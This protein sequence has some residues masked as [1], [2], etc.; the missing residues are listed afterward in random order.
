MSGGRAQ[1][2]IA[3][4]PSILVDEEIRKV[5]VS[6]HTRLPSM[7]EVHIR[8]ELELLA[9]GL[10][11]TDLP[12]LL[13][14]AIVSI[15]AVPVDPSPLPIG[16]PK[17]LITG[18][19]TSFEVVFDAD[20]RATLIL[21]GYDKSHRLHRGRKTAT[22]LMMNDAAIVAQVASSCGLLP[23]I[24]AGNMSP[25]P[26]II[27]NDLTDWD[28]LQLR[29]SLCGAQV[30]VD[31]LGGLHFSGMDLPISPL[32]GPILKWGEALKSFQ[33]RI[34]VA[35]QSLAAAV[36][37]MNVGLP[38]VGAGVG[39][40]TVPGMS[41]RLTADLVMARTVTGVFPIT[42]TSTNVGTGGDASTLGKA[43]VTESLMNFVRAEGVAMGD[44]G[45]MAGSKVMI[46][47]VG[48]RF[49]G[50]Y[51]VSQATHII[52][53]EKRYETHFTVGGSESNTL[54]SLIKGD[55]RREIG[56]MPGVVVGIVTNIAGVTDTEGGD[57]GRV[58]VKFAWM[59]PMADSNWA[60]IASPMAGLSNGFMFMPEVGDEVLVAFEHG[61]V[62][63]PYVVGGLWN[64]THKPPLAN[65]A[66]VVGG[67][68][69]KRTIKT[70]NHEVTFTDQPGQEKIEIIGGLTGMEKIIIDTVKHSIEIESNMD[71]SIK[72][73]AG[74]ID[75]EA[76][77]DITIK[78]A[79][80]VV[81]DCLNFNVKAKAK[82]A[83][84][85]TAGA[86]FKSPGPTNVEGSLIGIKSNG[87]A[88]IEGK[89]VQI[90]QTALV[91]LP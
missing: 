81:I 31:P 2:V 79:K 70:L 6:Q 1:V 10:E 58:K 71:I 32:P 12:T 83:L 91:V 80:D 21:R 63:R 29:A 62:N 43:L 35:G 47:G 20:S 16:I 56:R 26:Y 55:T 41:P 22:Y 18:E 76:V 15:K 7:F 13:I 87:P 34:T 49:S 54:S 86:D 78:T 42:G 84:E 48:Q 73:A 51:L 65:T 60:R 30:C 59:D 9:G 50:M 40:P 68:V 46:Q 85:G 66:A 82:V 14:G 25:Q 77:N 4:L 28:F 36:T 89:P 88:S 67:R 53:A 74:K 39:M 38:V 33:P 52:D 44:P 23:V 8:D 11:F 24:T 72:S 17:P 37:G 5:I 19:I 3:G 27:Q 45:L 57:V 90:N 69:A 61:D 64:K 75:I